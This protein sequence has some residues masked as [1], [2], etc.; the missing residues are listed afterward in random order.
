MSWW[1]WL[2]QVQEKGY[3]PLRRD[4]VLE[5]QSEQDLQIYPNPD[6]PDVCNV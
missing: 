4:K 5:W 6:D 1:S 2:Q 3:S